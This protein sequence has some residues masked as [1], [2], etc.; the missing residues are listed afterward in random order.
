MGQ[1]VGFFYDKKTIEIRISTECITLGQLLKIANLIDSGGEAK[2]Y[3]STHEIVVNGESD[4]RRGRKLR[5]QT[6]VEIENVVYRV[7]QK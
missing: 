7:L 2:F 1:K 3:L 4:N 6:T 5:D